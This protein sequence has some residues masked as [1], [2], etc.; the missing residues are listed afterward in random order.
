MDKIA[1][2]LHRLHGQLIPV[3]KA[4][5]SMTAD[6]VQVH[7]YLMA[8][9]VSSL[10]D[11]G[12]NPTEACGVLDITFA[13]YSSQLYSGDPDTEALEAAQHVNAVRENY[14]ADLFRDVEALTGFDLSDYF[15]DATRAESYATG[16]EKPLDDDWR[17]NNL[18]V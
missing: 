7:Q 1:V 5:S 15:T 14:N 8:D 9:K 4:P 2:V 6:A 3:W 11:N 18:L 16:T 12:L 13:E 10:L 17:L